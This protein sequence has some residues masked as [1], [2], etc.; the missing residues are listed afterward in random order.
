M[1]TFSSRLISK[2]ERKSLK[3]TISVSGEFGP[4]QM[5]SESTPMYQRGE[6]GP[7]QMVSESTPMYQ[8]GG[9]SPKGVDT[10]QCASKDARS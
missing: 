9:F 5:V 3:M 1:E 6:F 7:L 4:L 10:R 8:R 2:F